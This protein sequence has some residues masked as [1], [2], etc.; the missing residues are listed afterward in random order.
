MDLLVKLIKERSRGLRFI[1]T[2]VPCSGF[3]PRKPR[4]VLFD[5]YGTLLIQVPRR[6]LAVEDFIRRNRLELTPA[7]L[8]HGLRRE[9]DARHERLR[10]RGTRFP[11]VRIERIWGRLFPG[12]PD[13]ELR[14]LA[15]EFELAIHSC[16]PAPGCRDVIASAAALGIRLGIVSNAQFYTPLFL[17]ALLAR[18]PEELGFH[19]SLCIYSYRYQAGK[20]GPEL[21]ELAKSRLARLGIPPREAVMVG[22]DPRNDIAAARRAGFMTILVAGDKRTQRMIHA[23]ARPDAVIDRLSSLHRLI[24]HS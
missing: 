7:E 10:A 19:P 24:R 15:V 20:P 3:L 4:A 18:T 6:D 22:N 21:Y 8:S 2:G 9:V 17:Q 12:R 16:W 23:G 1:P 11:E 5:V 14:R 13:A